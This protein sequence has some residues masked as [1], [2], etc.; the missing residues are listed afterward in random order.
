[1][2][3]ITPATR[4]VTE[5]T[6]NMHSITNLGDAALLLPV[7]FAIL[8]LLVWQG[9]ERVAASFAAAIMICVALTVAAKLYFYGCD[10]RASA[11]DV[12]SPSGHTSLSAAFYGCGA[13]LITRRREGFPRAAIIMGAV[14]IIALVGISRVATRAHSWPDVLVGALGGAGCVVLFALLAGGRIPHVRLRPL[15]ASAAVAA[16]F[17]SGQHLSAEP[18]IRKIAVDLHAWSGACSDPSPLA[19]GKDG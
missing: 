9:H 6:L 4:E 7:S 3:P 1:M 11:G 19:P 2:S 16:I 14:L 12:L 13:L 18:L 5:T 17:L 10:I 8:V 15:I